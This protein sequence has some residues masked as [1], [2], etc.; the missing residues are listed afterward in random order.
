M[1]PYV[2][3]YEIAHGYRNATEEEEMPEFEDE[4]PRKHHHG[5]GMCPVYLII[6]ISMAGQ[7]VFL[8]FHEKALRH[9]KTLKRAKEIAQQQAKA[10]EVEAQPQYAPCPP[11]SVVDSTFDYS[12]EEPASPKDLEEPQDKSDSG[13]IFSFTD[14]DIKISGMNQSSSTITVSNNMV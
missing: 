12:I 3:E 5:F 1:Y 10:A 11:E 14:N 9:L 13:M 8:K 7:V 6:I 2:K 4:E